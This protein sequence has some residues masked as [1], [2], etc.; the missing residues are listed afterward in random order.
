MKRLLF[1]I[2]SFSV[3][4]EAQHASLVE[5]LDLKD[6]VGGTGFCLSLS[7]G[8]LIIT[9]E[10]VCSPDKEQK[11]VLTEHTITIERILKKSKELDLCSLACPKACI[12]LGFGVK[13]IECGDYAHSLGFPGLDHFQMETAQVCGT[14]FMGTVFP[15]QSGSPVLNSE[16]QVSGVI[17]G[18]FRD[19]GMGYFIPLETLKKF[20][21]IK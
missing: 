12:P 4:A 11:R 15:G 6:R 3:A 20:L 9:N 8:C 13:G 16:M 5:I 14:V 2:I 1:L 10:H 17:E 7:T 21:G 19:S 18:L